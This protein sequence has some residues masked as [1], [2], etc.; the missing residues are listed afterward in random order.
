M[1]KHF[2][3]ILPL[4]FVQKLNAQH[5]LSIGDSLPEF[6]IQKL[7]NSN[8]KNINTADFRNQLLIID[9]WS[10][11]CGG[12]VDALP[13]M[14]QLQQEFG[15]KIKILPVTNEPEKLVKI[16]W[17][18]NKNTKKLSLPSV[19]EDT[20]FNDYFKHRAV[21]HEVWVY[22]NKVI[23][24]TDGEYVDGANIKKVL[25][26][27]E[28]N[29]PVK[30]DFDRFDAK[31]N[32]LF[33][34]DGHQINLKNTPIQYAAISD[35]NESI[36][37]MSVFSG[38]SGIVRDNEKKNLRVFF[39]NFPI[40]SLYYINL[41]KV[42]HSESINAPKGSQNQ[43]LWEVKDPGKYKYQTG[44][45][46]KADWIKKN[47][48]CFES[49]YPDTGQ[50]DVEIAKSILEDLNHL[51]GLQ[52][53]WEKRKE[54]VYLLQRIDNTISIK[55]KGPIKDSES[56]MS[57]TGD[58]N[59]LRDTPLSTLVYRLNQE[60]ENPYVFDQSGYDGNVDL[61]LRFSSWTDI[62][63]IRKALQVYGLDLKEENQIVDKLVFKEINHKP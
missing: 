11:Y 44:S 51:L 21:P 37:N 61:A 38:G 24:I 27:D 42:H 47:G 25:D 23:A 26:G 54:K 46:Y 59:Q 17:K 31:K 22:K 7:I 9:F 40:Y 1:R 55:T 48:I 35:Y 12:C 15:S 45:G 52:V 18:K 30:Q 10:I 41:S 49:N 36:N 39:L 56:Y 57:T 60:T 8:Q 20:L 33:E 6:T 62:P 63:A 14:E 4:L 16:F 29:W 5:S 19:V 43:T 32:A 28:I 2:L 58:L 53:K 3:L 50:N 13:K 34:I